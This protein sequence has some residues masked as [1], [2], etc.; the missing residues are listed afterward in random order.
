MQ[1]DKIDYD[2]YWQQL[3]V[4]IT[5]NLQR[6]MPTQ[7]FWQ[8]FKHAYISHERVHDLMN[9]EHLED[10]LISLYTPKYM[11]GTMCSEERAVLSDL[12]LNNGTINL[13]RG[14]SKKVPLGSSYTLD[15]NRALW[16]ATRFG[17]QSSMLTTVT[18]KTS[19]IDCLWLERDEQE[20]FMLPKMLIAKAIQIVD[21]P[22]DR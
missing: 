22:V 20:V 13:Y 3:G 21:K 5:D 2:K 12:K 17:S 15:K 19:D 4:L 11:L 6:P 16:F 14:T 1:N 8:Y 7:R 10:Y 9:Q 18:V